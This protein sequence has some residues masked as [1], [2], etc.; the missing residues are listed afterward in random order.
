MKKVALWVLA[1]LITA[2]TAVYQRRTGPTYPIKGKTTIGSSEISYELLRTHETGQDCLVRIKIQNPDIG[3]VLLYKRHKT[4][5][6]WTNVP[7]ER[8]EDALVGALPH[9]PPAGKLEYKVV[10]SLEGKETSLSGENPVIIRFKGTVPLWI[11][12]FHVIVMFLAM[13]FSARA[14]IEALRPKSNPRKLALWTTGL[15]FIGGFILGPV[16]QKLAFGSLWTGFPLGYDLTDN[17]TLIAFIGWIVAVIAGRKGKPA[18]G[19]VLAAA[20]LLLIVFLIPHSLL[21]SELDYSNASASQP[22]IHFT[23]THTFFSLV[24]LA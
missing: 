11:L 14:G 18:R 9:Q 7:M 2:S 10:L 5:D 23:I 17:K 22:L 16:V 21:G 15:L 3:G 1:F 8:Q 13:L 20:I 4:P 24:R 19:W 6:P 12:I